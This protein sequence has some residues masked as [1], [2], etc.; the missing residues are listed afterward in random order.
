SLEGH[1]GIGHTRWATHGVPNKVNAH[2]HYGSR[3]E[4]VVVH[5]GIIENYLPLKEKLISEGYIFLSETDTE[6]LPHLI[7][8]YLEDDLRLAIVKSLRGV[9]G[10]YAIAVIS[11][12][13]EGKIVASRCGSPLIIGIGDGEMFIASDITAILNYTN[14]VI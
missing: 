1:V 14:K 12:K 7:G 4:V 11:S 2:P 9:E 10:S 6:V 8:S 5:N 3:S 13:D